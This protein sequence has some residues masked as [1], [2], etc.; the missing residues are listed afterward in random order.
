MGIRRRLEKLEGG[1]GRP[2]SEC[3]IDPNAP[4]EYVVG[5]KDPP[6]PEEMRELREWYKRGMPPEEEPL[7]P[8]P[9]CG[10]GREIIIDWLDAPTRGELRRLE[11]EMRA[12][13]DWVPDFPLGGWSGEG[14]GV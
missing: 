14:G 11:A 6:T 13:R 2:C 9:R 12:R 5:G 10:C 4:I 3:G 8:G 7:G 1:S